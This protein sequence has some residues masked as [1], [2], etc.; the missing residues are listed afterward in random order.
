MWKI[1][2]IADLVRF[3]HNWNDGILEYGMVG[4]D[5]QSERNFWGKSKKWKSDEHHRKMKLQHCL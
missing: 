2:K 1:K 3:A 4:I 5:D